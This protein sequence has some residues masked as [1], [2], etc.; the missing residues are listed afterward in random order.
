M[1]FTFLELAGHPRSRG[2]IPEELG[3][4]PSPGQG[5]KHLD[6]LFPL[7][8]PSQ[9]G[10]PCPC[11]HGKCSTNF[12]DPDPDGSHWVK[13]VLGMQTNVGLGAECQC[14]A[15]LRGS[16]TSQDSSAHTAWGQ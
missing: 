1:T 2:G 8:S 9:K 10:A 6:G 3:K 4:M 16:G 11:L 14:H 15:G 12:G 7:L 13:G 5:L